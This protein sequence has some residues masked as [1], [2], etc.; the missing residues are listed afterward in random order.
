MRQGNKMYAK[1]HSQ[2]AQSVLA[3]CDNKL[4]GKTLK[5]GKIHFTVSESFYGGEVIEK[6]RLL[7]LLEEYGN[8]NM[9]GEE[10]VNAALEK[11]LISE[12]SIIR[13]KGIPH[14]QIFKLGL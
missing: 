1:V 5:Q 12:G 7:E 9:V 2:G 11:G 13:I 10:C 4:L 6:E 8:I 3:A 14:V